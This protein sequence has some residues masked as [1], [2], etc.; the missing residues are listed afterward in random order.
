MLFNLL[1]RVLGWLFI[2]KAGRSAR[3]RAQITRR[4]IIS[5]RAGAHA[6][7]FVF[8]QGSVRRMTGT[9]QNADA[10]LVF[11]S[12]ALGL[13]CFL[14]PRI[15]KR[16]FDGV[17]AERI[18]IEGNLYLLLWFQGMAQQVFPLAGVPKLAHKPPN[19][20]IAHRPGQAVKARLERHPVADQLDP[21]WTEAHTAKAKLLMMRVAA[22]EKPPL[23]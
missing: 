8:D 15:L 2:A 5:I 12:A 13:R 23:F 9:A 4:T 11:D 16:I 18:G 22:G 6:H 3:F 10:G 1:L 17:Q 7:Q 20:Y 14:S 19:A 21:D